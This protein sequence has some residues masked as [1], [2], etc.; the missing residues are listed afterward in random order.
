MSTA[1]D[2]LDLPQYTDY[3]F[4]AR[5]AFPAFVARMQQQGVNMNEQRWHYCN[6]IILS[7]SYNHQTECYRG[8]TFLVKVGCAKG[9]IKSINGEDKLCMEEGIS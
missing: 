7:V 2:H 4:E 8:D 3:S 5:S 1:W 9:F 6:A